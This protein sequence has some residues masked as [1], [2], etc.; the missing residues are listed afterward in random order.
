MFAD[1]LKEIM[2]E[3]K[4]TS[5]Q[6]SR[7][8]GIGRSLISMYRSGQVNPSEKSLERLSRAL[9]CEK[10]DLLGIEKEETGI[11]LDDA[12]I[13][14]LPIMKAAKLLGINHQSLRL[15]LQQGRFPW[16]YAI[17]TSENRWVYFIN[18][19][20]FAEIE[21]VPYERSVPNEQSQI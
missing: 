4:I 7:T 3:Q 19:K 11:S 16:G 5:A 14:K 20:K 8:S 6:L 1:N 2:E 15:G 17:H 12:P 10:E 13:T 9:G 21:G 18:A